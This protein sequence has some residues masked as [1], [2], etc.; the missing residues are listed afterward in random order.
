VYEIGDEAVRDEVLQSIY[1]G[2]YI[3]SFY[4]PYS[5]GLSVPSMVYM[6]Y[7]DQLMLFRADKGD[8][9]FQVRDEKG[10]KLL[11]Q[12]NDGEKHTLKFYN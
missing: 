2:P 10:M 3:I 12:K 4:S 7:D 5:L 1:G 8:R 9:M 6:K 11:L